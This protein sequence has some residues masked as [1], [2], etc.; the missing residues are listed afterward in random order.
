MFVDFDDDGPVPARAYEDMLKEQH[1][2]IMQQQDEEEGGQGGERNVN[3]AKAKAKRSFVADDGVRYCWDDEEQ[4]WVVDDDPD[5]SDDEEEEEEGNPQDRGPLV[6][7]RVGSKAKASAE[8]K[9]DAEGDDDDDDDG[10]EGKE[11]GGAQDQGAGGGAEKRRR[12]RKNRKGK[13]KG[14]S[15]WVYISGLPH[16]VTPEELKAHFSKVPPH[17]ALI[18]I[19]TILSPPFSSSSPPSPP[20]HTSS[21]SS[22]ITLSPPSSP[23]L[24]Q[25]GL[26]AISPFDQLPKIKLYR[27]PDGRGKGDASVCYVAEESVAMA[28]EVLNGGYIRPSH[29]VSVTRAEFQPK[30]GASGHE[31]PAEGGQGAQTHKR[32]RLT[33][34]QVKVAQAATQQALSWNE[35]DD[36]GVKRSQALRIV[37]LTGM[38]E[39]SNFRDPSFS[40][41]LETDLAGE[42]SKCGHVEKITVFSQNPAGVAIVKF[43]TAFA[44]QECVKL[45]DGRYFAGRKVRCF[46]WDGVT[47][48]SGSGPGAGVGA[49]LLGEEKE[50]EE[51][52]RLDEFGDWLD[53]DQENLPEEFQLRVER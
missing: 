38:F 45:M 9:G 21:S 32:P 52:E 36:I 19:L 25:V 16:D 46:F 42:C 47:N 10:E 28:L 43:G 27:G 14:P 34:A 4:D 41:E 15:L 5:P 7:S 51:A 50:K 40:D 31:T 12:K 35:A 26:I 33:H 49:D 20:P 44:S 53:K 1:A 37:V 13:A 23:L 2:R 18:P 30:E 11:G 17:S 29:Q 6:G 3:K 22:L 48:Y 24:S 39:P 8:S